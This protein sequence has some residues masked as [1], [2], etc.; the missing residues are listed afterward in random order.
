MKK[1]HNIQISPNFVTSTF[2]KVIKLASFDAF[3]RF[4][5][6]G[7]GRGEKRR[8]FNY[9]NNIHP[10]GRGKFPIRFK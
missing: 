8:T 10:F 5:I 1:E 6:F 2:E 4:S 3:M 7:H 9:I